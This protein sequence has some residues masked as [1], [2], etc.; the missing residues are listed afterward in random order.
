MATTFTGRA[1]ANG[2]TYH[3]DWATDR[4]WAGTCRELVVTRTDGVQH[5]ATFGFR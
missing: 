4:S 5:R 3:D 1:S 2:D